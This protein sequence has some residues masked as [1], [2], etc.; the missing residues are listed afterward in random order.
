MV[1]NCIFNNDD[2]SWKEIEISSDFKVYRCCTI[3]AFH[4]LDK[5]F[6]DEYLDS[7]PDDWNDLREHSLSDIMKIYEDYIKP[8]KWSN[9]DTT[10]QC[11]KR[12]CLK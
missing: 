3:Q 2:G 12:I 5:T 9:I 7:L 11:C 10:P 4:Q 6:F 8:E 1:V